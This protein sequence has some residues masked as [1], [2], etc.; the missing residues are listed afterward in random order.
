MSTRSTYWG[1]KSILAMAIDVGTTFSSASYTFLK[2]GESLKYTTLTMVRNS[3]QYSSTHRKISFTQ[4]QSDN[5][6]DSI[7]SQRKWTDR[8]VPWRLSVPRKARQRQRLRDVD[9]VIEAVRQSGVQCDALTRALALPKEDEMPAKDKYTVFNRRSKGYRKGI[10]KVHK[11]T[12]L[13]LREN[14][15][16]F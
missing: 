7:T 1:S 4:G 3:P 11:R 14:P 10:H 15:L 13:T 6:W 2:A 8:K 9:E 5:Q 16:G 12:R